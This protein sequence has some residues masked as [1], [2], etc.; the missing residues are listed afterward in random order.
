MKRWIPVA[1]LVLGFATGASLAGPLYVGGSWGKTDIEVKE[2]GFNFNQN[3]SSYKLFV[4]YRFLKFF[5]VEG[6]YVDMGSPSDTSGGTDTTIKSK[7][8]DAFAVGV[9]PAGRHFEIFGKLGIAHWDKKID[10]SGTITGSSDDTGN[11]RVTGIGVGF[12]FTSHI[13]IRA[14]YEKFSFPDTD[15]VAMTTFGIDLRL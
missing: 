2:S 13:A 10:Q 5:G 1:V 12:L 9:L 3:D 14:E 4:G 15:K 6:G 7:A 8:Y 11:N